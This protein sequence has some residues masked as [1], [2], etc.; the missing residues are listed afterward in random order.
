[1]LTYAHTRPNCT[2]SSPL[3]LHSRYVFS[4]KGVCC[5]WDEHTSLSHRPIPHHHTFYVPFCF[6]HPIEQRGTVYSIQHITWCHT[7]SFTLRSKS[8]LQILYSGKFWLVQNFVEI[9]PSLC[10]CGNKYMM[11]WPHP[12]QLMASHTNQT[13]KQRSKVVHQRPSL[14]F[15]WRPL[16]SIKVAAIGKKTGSEG[17]RTA[18]LEHLLQ[19]HWYWC[20]GS[21]HLQGRQTIE[22]QLV[23]TGT[24]S[25]Q[26]THIIMSS[27]SVFIFFAVLFSQKQVCP[28]KSW[29][30]ATSI[31]FRLCGSLSSWMLLGWVLL[32]NIK[33]LEVV[34]QKI[35]LEKGLADWKF[36]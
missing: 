6:C 1:M 33:H 22:N 30:F 8:M 10:I 14:P 26:C 19:V 13:T 12:Y 17:F 25:Y 23:H 21:D 35:R 32:W 18:D 20:S 28:W 2:P 34:Y 36:T 29:K 31:N 5:V 15:V 24:S 9:H 11:F 16:Q 4:R 7:N 27:I 3:N